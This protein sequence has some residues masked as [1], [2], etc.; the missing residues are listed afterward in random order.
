MNIGDQMKRFFAVVIAVNNL[1][2]A[3]KNYQR[4]GFQLL[5]R[6]PREEWGLEAAQLKVGAE[7]VIE[8]L[9]PVA[10]EKPVAQTV[11]KFLDR[12]GEGVY[13]VAIEVEDIDAVHRH[14]KESGARIVADIHS[15]PSHPDT[16]IMWISPKSTNGVFLEFMKNSILSIGR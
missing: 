15:A 13:E 8:L 12:N 5:S 16:K 2:E 7:S 9:A 1:D 6:H 3:I 14:V 10:M 11:R 4:L